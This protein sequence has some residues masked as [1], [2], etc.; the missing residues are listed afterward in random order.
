MI[1]REMYMK[2]IRPFI[3]TDLIKV[4]TGIRRCGKS[5]M[6]ELIK[7]ELVESGV[8]PK[9]FV[10]INFEDLNYVHLQN[11]KALHDEIT[12]RAAE[13][14][15]RIYLFFDLH[16]TSRKKRCMF[17]CAICLPLMKQSS[18]SLV[19]MTVFVITIRNMLCLWMSSI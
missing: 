11:A 12:K 17:R 1:K 18:V 4:M 13:I 15:G 2:R 5:V 7:E 3:G 6:L 19:F 8:N 9:Q 16:V 10:A 14:G